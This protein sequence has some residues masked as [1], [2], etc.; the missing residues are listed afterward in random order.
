VSERE[1]AQ[2]REREIENARERAR[3]QGRARERRRS[4]EPRQADRLCDTDRKEG[5][6]GSGGGVPSNGSSN[7]PIGYTKTLSV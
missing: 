4:T 2:D 3:A 6:R 5:K 1:S 7:F